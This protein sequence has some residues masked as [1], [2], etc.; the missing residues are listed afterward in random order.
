MNTVS[1]MLCTTCNKEYITDETDVEGICADCLAA[2]MHE[3]S[4]VHDE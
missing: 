2:F 1:T 3:H 4:E